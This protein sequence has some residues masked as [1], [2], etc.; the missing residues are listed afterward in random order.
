MLKYQA[1]LSLIQRGIDEITPFVSSL[2]VMLYYQRWQKTSRFVWL[3]FCYLF[4]KYPIPPG[5]YQLI[6]WSI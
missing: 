3:E 4:T 2:F 5:K 6:V 1:I